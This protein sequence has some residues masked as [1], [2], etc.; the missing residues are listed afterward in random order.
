MENI[1]DKENFINVGTPVKSLS[2]SHDNFALTPGKT[3]L[4]LEGDVAS[5]ALKPVNNEAR[6]SLKKNSPI[7]K[8]ET[9][10]SSP[11]KFIRQ[12]D[13]AERWTERTS[14]VTKQDHKLNLENARSIL[15][16]VVNNLPLDL[17]RNQWIPEAVQEPVTASAQVDIDELSSLLGGLD[18]DFK[19]TPR[20]PENPIVNLDQSRKLKDTHKVDFVEPLP[21]NFGKSDSFNTPEDM[22]EGE[23][24]PA[25][26]VDVLDIL[27]TNLEKTDK[28]DMDN[29]L[30]T[31]L[32]KTEKVDMLDILP[33]DLEKTDKVGMDNVL[34]VSLEKT[35]V[36]MDDI[37]PTNLEKTE[38]VDMLDILPTNLEKTDKV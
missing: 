35:D 34:P 24:C 26:E 25:T 3:T 22:A 36:D 10:V 7:K 38:K 19:G 13:S 11:Y 5:C 32:E 30:A 9:P 6:L 16:D 17:H 29:V 2:G 31:D 15:S 18:L 14:V 21:I 1:S 8:K 27:P 23:F 12:L 28:V 4:T 33:T 20:K 37:L